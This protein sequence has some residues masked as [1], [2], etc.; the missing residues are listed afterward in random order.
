MMRDREPPGGIPRSLGV[1]T[2]NCHDFTNKIVILSFPNLDI[3]A[4]IVSRYSCKNVGILVLYRML[5]L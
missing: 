3:D 1:E 4:I 2:K 5:K